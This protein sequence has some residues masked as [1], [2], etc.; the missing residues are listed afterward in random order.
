MSSVPVPSK[1]DPQALSPVELPCKE[2]ECDEELVT[3]LTDA[4][5]EYYENLEVRRRH[6]ASGEVH[7]VRFLFCSTECRGRFETDTPDDVEEIVRE[8]GSGG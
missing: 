8:E 4:D 7:R 6:E 2:P 5:I 3:Y 1:G